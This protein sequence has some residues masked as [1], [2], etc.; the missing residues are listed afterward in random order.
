[1][2]EINVY[3]YSTLESINGFTQYDSNRIILIPKITE[4]SS[5]VCHFCNTQSSEAYVVNVEDYSYNSE[6]YYKAIVPN[7]LLLENTPIYIY[8]Y[9][10]IKDEQKTVFFAK[11][12]VYKR[13]RPNGY[14][15]ENNSKYFIVEQISTELKA[16]TQRVKD[17]ENGLSGSIEIT[18]GSVTSAKLANNSVVA[19]K[20]VNGA[21]TPEKTNFFDTSPNLFNPETV[22]VGAIIKS[23]GMLSTGFTGWRSSDYIP[24]KA[25]VTYYFSDD[26]AKYQLSTCALYDENKKYITGY[27]NDVDGAFNRGY[28]ITAEQDC[29]LRVSLNKVF[30]EKLQIEANGITDYKS[31]D[32]AKIKDSYIPDFDIADI[33]EKSITGVLI[34]DKTITPDNTDFF[35]V[36]TNLFN[37]ETV[38]AGAQNGN[39]FDET[40]FPNWRTTD[41]I[42]VKANITYYC[43]VD[44]VASNYNLCSLFKEDKK[45]FVSKFT[46]DQNSFTPSV[47]G[48]VRLTLNKTFPDKFQIEAD[49]ITDY[50]EYGVVETKLK[51]EYMSGSQDISEKWANKKVL[52]M[53]DSITSFT[54]FLGWTTYFKDYIKAEKVINLAVSGATWKDKEANQTYDGAPKP[55]TTGN[56]IG[57]QLQKAINAKEN[58]DEN[59]TDFDVVIIAAG[60]NDSFVSSA[61]TIPSVENQFVSAYGAGK[62]TVVPIDEVDRQTFAG[63]M[64]YTYQK[65]QETYPN[66]KMVIC[67]PIQECYESYTSIYNKGEHFRYIASRLSVEFWNTRDCGICNL[68]ESP[69]DTIDYDNPSG[70]ES[71]VK[72]DLTDGIHPSESGAKKIASYNALMFKRMYI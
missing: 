11:K 66:A 53:G 51:S 67:S 61:E 36:S 52:I 59:Y 48:Y 63:I 54:G 7:I 37:P 28:S 6:L 17:L 22:S 58:G 20:I 32:Y 25:N 24:I 72:R 34:A 10:T 44:G 68:Y 23:S 4:A 70:E 15:Y 69:T 14:V 12:N 43:S 65:L 47:D 35:R 38:S 8:L 45:T 62:F 13:P 27:G 29:Y 18:D 71:T 50:K 40:N 30:P 42:P 60:T 33:P 1:M 2:T 3:D 46:N 39:Y 55:S 49:E 5:A 16:L 31:Y 26:G 19:N 21:I 64:R 57:N 41:Y 56:V 9:I